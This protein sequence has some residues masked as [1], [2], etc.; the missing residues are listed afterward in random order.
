MMIK[1]K[2]LG[3]LLRSWIE[4][5]Y[6]YDYDTMIVLL[7]C[8]GKARRTLSIQQKTPNA[9]TFRM[10]YSPIRQGRHR[11][12]REF[13][14][15]VCCSH[16]WREPREPWGCLKVAP[17]NYHG[18]SSSLILINVPHQ[19]CR[20]IG[21]FSISRRLPR[22]TTIAVG[23]MLGTQWSVYPVV[24]CSGLQA[25]I[26]ITPIIHIYIYI[27]THVCIIYIYGHTHIYI[28]IMYNIYIYVHIYIYMYI[29]TC[30]YIYIHIYIYYV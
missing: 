15:W 13:G 21:L 10:K 23:A 7:R 27:Y 29:H 5:A 16:L 3:T 22:D 9:S 14:H 11:H 17:K 6:H 28:Y 30:V 18:K 2:D 4:F 24:G 20:F 26:H 1:L 8:L 19:N 25:K 12:R